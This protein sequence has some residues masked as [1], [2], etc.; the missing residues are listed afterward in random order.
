MSAVIWVIL[1]SVFFGTTGTTQT[2]APPAAAPL[3]IG[4][5]RMVTGGTLMALLGLVL[6]RRRTGRWPRFSAPRHGWRVPVALGLAALGMAAYQV[7]FFAGTRANGVA[8]GTIVTLG[9]APLVAGLCEWLVRRRRPGRPWFI[10]TALAVAG[11]VLLSGGAADVHLSGLA[12]SATA[13]AAYG[14]EMVALKIVLDQGWT[15][16]DAVSW[17]MGLAAVATVPTLI[18][19]DTSWL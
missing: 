13:G 5:V 15:S 4:S 2:F 18:A 1:A 10:A 6:H 14:A 12:L 3:S 17:V 19:G 7:T 16:S 11:V 9:A 8:V